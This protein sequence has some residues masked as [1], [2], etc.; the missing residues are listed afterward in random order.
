M[1]GFSERADGIWTGLR[2]LRLSVVKIDRNPQPN[3]VKKSMTDFIP[4]GE[5]HVH[6]HEI[7]VHQ[8][9][10]GLAGLFLICNQLRSTH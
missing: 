9:V 3:S 6:F 8:S 7:Q 5:I 10:P 4:R 2:L 1:L